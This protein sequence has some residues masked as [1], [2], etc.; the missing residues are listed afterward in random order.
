MPARFLRLIALGLL[1]MSCA[2][3]AAGQ[4]TFTTDMLTV[5]GDRLYPIAVNGV[6]G[7]ALIDPGAFHPT[8][9]A[10]GFATR[11][12]LVFTPD[13]SLGSVGPVK[14]KGARGTMV[15]TLGADQVD[16]ETVWS[17][18]GYSY[19]AADCAFGPQVLGATIVR[20]EL[21]EPQPG[22]KTVK[23]PIL[24]QNGTRLFGNQPENDGAIDALVEIAG[25]PMGVRFDLTR[26]LTVATAGASLAIALSHGGWLDGP[27]E[28]SEIQF[29]VARP[30][31]RLRLS[32]PLMI[33]PLSLDSVFARI[34][35]YGDAS[36]LATTRPKP[37][38]TGAP[39]IVVNGQRRKRY[40][41]I[42]IGADDMARCSSITFDKRGKTITLSCR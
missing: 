37:T 30:V 21:H 27:V 18:D 4:L 29:G 26:R 40:E 1:T 13:N 22:E 36:R 3:A 12:G 35:D 38:E 20:F 19:S 33:G 28:T 24:K 23:L 41:R 31:R 42:R 9:C 16:L 6:A 25:R 15:F 10:A 32:E 34:E 7:T 14:P 8:Q 11:T 2:G 5:R 39:D 17:P